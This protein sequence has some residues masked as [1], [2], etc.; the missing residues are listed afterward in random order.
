MRRT[1]QEHYVLPP[2][3]QKYNTLLFQKH[4]YLLQ[5]IQIQLLTYTNRN[6]FKRLTFASKL[7]LYKDD[8]YRILSS[9]LCPGPAQL[10]LALGSELNDR[11]CLFSALPLSLSLL[12]SQVSHCGITRHSLPQLM[13]CNITLP[14]NGNQTC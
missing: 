4:A 10:F 14:S 6:D 1:E 8:L 13:V 3:I 11:K 7:V 9:W 2:K 5:I 12:F